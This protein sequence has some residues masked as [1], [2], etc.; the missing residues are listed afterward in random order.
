VSDRGYP[1]ALRLVFERE[2]EEVRL[3]EAIPIDMVVPRGG[4]LEVDDAKHAGFAVRVYGQKGDL[5]YRRPMADPLAREAEIYTGVP[6]Q[7]FERVPVSIDF[8][9]FEVVVPNVDQ[10]VEV[11]L[12]GSPRRKGS[13]QAAAR[14]IV[15][16]PVKPADKSKP[17]R[18]G[19]S[20]GRVS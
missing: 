4:D 19:E 8:V 5:L 12:M 1:G 6:E 17:V 18:G 14:P 10:D 11:E 9:Q 20:G 16:V 2:G 3:V 15:R 13:R 7:P